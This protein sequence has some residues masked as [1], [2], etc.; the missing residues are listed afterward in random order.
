MRAPTPHLALAAVWEFIGHINKY[1]DDEKPWILAKEE[2]SR[3]RLAHCLREGLEALR[4]TA[5]LL[6]AF[7]PH[8]AARMWADLGLEGEPSLRNDGPRWHGLPEGGKTSLSGPLF[9]RIEDKD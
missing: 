5:I 1:L 8:T 7:M 2:G 9:P 3:D 4:F 6:L